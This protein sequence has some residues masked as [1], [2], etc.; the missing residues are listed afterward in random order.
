MCIRDSCDGVSDMLFNTLQVYDNY[1]SSISSVN[2]T[3]AQL[4]N[5]DNI[6]MQ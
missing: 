5:N 2:D 1:F 4:I 6:N 3:T